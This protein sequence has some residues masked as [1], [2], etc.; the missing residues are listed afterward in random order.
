MYNQ[1]SSDR[2]SEVWRC[3]WGSL[4]PPRVYFVENTSVLWGWGTEEPATW[5]LT[6]PYETNG[7]PRITETFCKR[8]ATHPRLRIW[9][10]LGGRLGFSWKVDRKN[11][12]WL[13]LKEKC[14]SLLWKVVKQSAVFF[15]PLGHLFTP[16]NCCEHLFMA[17]RRWKLCWI[18]KKD[19]WSNGALLRLSFRES[20][21]SWYFCPLRMKFEY[22]F[23][24]K[25]PCMF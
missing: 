22:S 20:Y 5:E 6:W 3:V 14:A 8:F 16:H 25:F 19:C 17:L 4:F 15:W 7:E 11:Q 10:N 12:P 21:S 2:M 23:F 18:K 24:N 1:H 9:Q 13:F